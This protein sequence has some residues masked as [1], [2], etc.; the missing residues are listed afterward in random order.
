MSR[1]ETHIIFPC[2]YEFHEII[3]VSPVVE[4]SGGSNAPRECPIHGK[5]CMRKLNK[6]E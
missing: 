6:K 3:K 1:I 5:E 2:G 4:F